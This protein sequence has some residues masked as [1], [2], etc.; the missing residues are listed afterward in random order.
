VTAALLSRERTDAVDEAVVAL[1]CKV[2][3]V[4]DEGLESRQDPEGSE[5]LLSPLDGRPGTYREWAADYYER[6]VSLSAVEHVNQHRALTA[7]VVALL[8]PEASLEELA[9]DASEIGY[10]GV[11]RRC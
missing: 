3:P 10:L 11:L 4:L 9:A 2:E 1:R 6:E 7:E 5:F 8:N